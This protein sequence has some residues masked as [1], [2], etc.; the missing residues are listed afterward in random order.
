MFS[1]IILI[2][3]FIV[4]YIAVLF[5]GLMILDIFSKIRKDRFRILLKKTEEGE[6]IWH[7]IYERYL[8][9]VFKYHC[10]FK[11]KKYEYTDYGASF[12]GG[13]KFLQDLSIPGGLTYCL[14]DRLI[15]KFSVYFENHKIDYE[16]NQDYI[17]DFPQ[18]A[19]KIIR[20][21]KVKKIISERD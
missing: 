9:S 8:E 14:S 5:S 11:G 4:I 6:I 18:E 12:I 19:N 7:R 17:E 10:Y 3:Y 1:S 2:V 20:K 21:K 15:D 13:G 16:I